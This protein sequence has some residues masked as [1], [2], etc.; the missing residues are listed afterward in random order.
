MWQEEEQQF[1]NQGAKDINKELDFP[2]NVSEWKRIG[3]E[4]GYW[5][6]FRDEIRKKDM[7]ELIKLICNREVFEDKLNEKAIKEYYKD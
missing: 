5:N 4:R 6:Y 7:E 2:Y 1:I 3:I